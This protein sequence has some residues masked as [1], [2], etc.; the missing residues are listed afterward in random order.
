MASRDR[1]TCR[2]LSTT[3]MRRAVSN[4]VENAVKYD[5]TA[6]VTLTPP[7]DRVVTL[8][9]TEAPKGTV[10][11]RRCP[12]SICQTWARKDSRA[13]GGRT[14]SGSGPITSGSKESRTIGVELRPPLLA[15]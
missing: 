5:G 3:T 4:M 6:A 10:V 14:G 15:R 12:P 1:A 9:R 7:T 11:A 2:Y 13:D 8:S